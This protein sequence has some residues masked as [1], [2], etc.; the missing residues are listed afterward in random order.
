M[1]M[2]LVFDATLALSLVVLAWAGLRAR[3]LFT[4]IVIFVLFGLLIAIAWVRLYAPDIALAEAAIGSGLTGALLMAALGRFE[5][6]PGIR[7]PIASASRTSTIIN[8]C[9][10]MA[11]F[12]L[13]A[14]CVIQAPP[15]AA[16]LG[17][18][19]RAAIAP[20]GI[21]N[22]VTSVVLDLRGY[23]TMLEIGVLLLALLGLRSIHPDLRLNPEFLQDPADPLLSAMIRLFTPVV[24]T[25][26]GYTMWVGADAPGGAFQAG[27]MLGGV[28][29]MV[30]LSAIPFTPAL[31]Q[32]LWRVGA[33]CG[34]TVYTLSAACLVFEGALLQYPQALRK[35]IMLLI[36]SAC[37]LSIAITLL[38][39][40]A[41]CGLMG[42]RE[43]T[44]RNHRQAEA[45]S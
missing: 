7:E 13:L 10:T 19:A 27:A 16:G 30:L 3:N 29:V 45:P 22:P 25:F 12:A 38:T 41:G 15:T 43:P 42:K 11:V 1:S 39:L 18:L 36:E 8:A 2:P 21:G 40:F 6:R 24:V 4:G 33:A 34:F 14:T 9:L 44:S 17:P 20:T 32:P 5:S 35:Y 28:G 26:A 37:T 31:R 23:D